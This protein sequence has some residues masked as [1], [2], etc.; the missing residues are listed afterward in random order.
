MEANNKEF[1]KPKCLKKRKGRGYANRIE[2]EILRKVRGHLER[3]FV[4][5]ILEIYCFLLRSWS[6]EH[7]MRLSAAFIALFEGFCII[8]MLP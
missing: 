1:K 8:A 7:L 2:T 4:T 5:P 6:D 3:N